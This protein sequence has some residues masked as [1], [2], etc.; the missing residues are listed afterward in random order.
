MNPRIRLVIFLIFLFAFLISAPLVVL[1]TAGYRFD[2]SARTIVRTGVLN[3]STVPRGAT[4]SIDGEE[5]TDKTPSLLDDILPGKRFVEIEKDGYTTW[6]KTLEVESRN[7]TFVFDAVLFLKNEP[8][9]EDD[10]T[11]IEYS[12]SPDSHHMVYLINEGS[13]VELW[14]T[15]STS[16]SQQLLTRLPHNDSASYVLS[17][18]SKSTYVSLEQQTYLGDSVSIID[19]A[20][21]VTVETHDVLQSTDDYW[22]DAGNDDGLFIRTDSNL[23]R[24]LMSDDS[25]ASIVP[26]N[27]HTAVT[28]DK[29]YVLTESSDKMVLARQEEEAVSI[30]TYLPFG[31]Y[32]FLPA[33]DGLVMLQDVDRSRLVVVELSE[34]EQPILFS[35]DAE[36]WQWNDDGDRLLYSDGFDIEIYTRSSHTTQTLTRISEEISTLLWYPQGNVIIFAADQNLTAFELDN[37]DGHHTTTLIEGET[38]N[39]WLDDEGD[40]LFFSGAVNDL[41]GLYSKQLQQ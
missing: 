19:V 21:G 31:T 40:Y 20:R 5:N 39:V 9:L 2:V 17:W 22:W 34:S 3:L 37:R 24:L 36:L 28:Q 32:R 10:R 15:G 23:Y 33:P 18:S 38:E 4:V 30:I 12:L 35:K 25:V 16:D 26:E 27:P 11:A 6:Q 7:T 13:W 1:Y 29:T 41:D 8:F 14:T